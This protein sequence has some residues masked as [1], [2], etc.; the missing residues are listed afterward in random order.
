MY[1]PLEDPQYLVTVGAITDW[2]RITS[3]EQDIILKLLYGEGL[4]VSDIALSLPNDQ[5]LYESKSDSSLR[6]MSSLHKKQIKRNNL[7]F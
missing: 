4:S 3:G 2:L 7:N 6:F 1:Q 5:H